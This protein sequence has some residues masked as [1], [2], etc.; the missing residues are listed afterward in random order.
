MNWVAI[1]FFFY[2]T[3]LVVDTHSKHLMFFSERKQNQQNKCC[4]FFE[5]CKRH[6]KKGKN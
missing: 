3:N 5:I 1:D 2:F 4:M 6:N